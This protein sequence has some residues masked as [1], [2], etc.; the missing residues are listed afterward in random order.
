MTAPARPV[1]VADAK[2]RPLHG[3]SF[4]ARAAAPRLRIKQAVLS[5]IRVLRD[6]QALGAAPNEVLTA[7]DYHG[8]SVTWA[9]DRLDGAPGYRLSLTVTDGH[10]DHGAIVAGADGHISVAV[11]ALTGEPPLTPIAIGDLLNDKAA[12]DPAAR[13]ALA[14]LSYR[15]KFLA[16]SWRFDTYFGRDTLMSV[17]L[18]MPALQP[19]AVETGLR[20]VLER[21]SPAGEVA[22]EEDIGEFAILDHLKADGARSAAPTYNYNMIDGNVMLAPVARAWLL[23]DPR[24][25]AARRRFSRRDRP[26]RAAGR[27]ADA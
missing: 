10:L 20:S 14:F 19:Q 11:T 5:S 22:H 13:R 1:T 24:G 26:W 23:D 6:Y 2:G 25:R 21:L 18:L 9:R 17:R 15:E 7:P 16:G 27:C 12:A 8:N 3:V 4:V